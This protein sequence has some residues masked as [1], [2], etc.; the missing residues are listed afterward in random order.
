MNDLTK[1]WL[2]KS[3]EEG[4]EKN[5]F[6][7]SLAKLPLKMT[8]MALR[9]PIETALLGYGANQ[10]LRPM[11]QGYY[12]KYFGKNKGYRIPTPRM[13]YYEKTL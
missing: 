2:K 5:A 12:N 4:F 10:F 3:S 8:G 7:F 13:N 9:N 6:L 11:A 1:Y